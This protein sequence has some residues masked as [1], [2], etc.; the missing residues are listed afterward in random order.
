MLL[1]VA[2]AASIGGVGTLIGTPPNA[3]VVS[4]L[5]QRLGYTISFVDWL[6]IGLPFV[7]VGLPVTWYVL[8]VV[9]YPPAIEDASAARTEAKRYLREAGGPSAA[10]RRVLLITGATAGLWLLGGLEFL[11][12]GVLP[13]RLYV[14]LFGG[15]GGHLFGAGAHQGSLY[16]VL[17]GL[18]AVPALAIADVIDWGDVQDI[19]WGTVVLLGGGI[20]L[21]DALSTTG[22]T[23]WLADGL[24]NSLVGAPVLAVALVV[25]TATI[26]I[27]ELASNTAMAAISVPVL[28]SMGPAFADAFGASPTVASVFLAVTGGI[29]ASFGFALPVATPPN[30]IAFGTGQMTRA[31]MLRPGVVLDAVMAVV[32][33]VLAFGLFAILW[34]VV[35]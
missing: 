17:V 8:A 28:I 32:T 3:I 30:A 31:Q 29:A 35:T 33:A 6:L 25:A 16:F 15:S 11:F 4:Q 9:V 18:A 10:E 34:P 23:R 24:V 14:T 19:D 5:T 2:Y 13:A 1:G 20:S 22:A 26:V 7:A 12:E 27:S 21:A